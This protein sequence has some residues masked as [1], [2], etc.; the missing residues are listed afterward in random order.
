[1]KLTQE[2]IQK[3]ITINDKIRKE[4]IWARKRYQK[5]IVEMDEMVR[6][7]IIEDYEIKERYELISDNEEFCESKNVYLGDPFLAEECIGVLHPNDDDFFNTNWNEF[8]WNLYDGD[9]DALKHLHF[10][11][12]MHYLLLHSTLCIKDILAID[13]FWL[14][15][16]VIYQ[17]CTIKN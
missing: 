12:T 17:F 14:E 3:F 9:Y 4:E 2:D 15:L 8:D 11:Y 7:K 1:M 10:G 13:D 6:K 16:K 5:L